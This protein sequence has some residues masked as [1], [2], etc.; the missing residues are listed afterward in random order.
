MKQ[1]LKSG[2]LP[3]LQD[4]QPQTEFT[5]LLRLRG[6]SI[7]VNKLS[8]CFIGSLMDVCPFKKAKLLSMVQV[9]KLKV[10][11]QKQK[12]KGTIAE[13]VTPTDLAFSVKLHIV[14]YEIHLSKKQGGDFPEGI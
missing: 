10:T 12:S 11:F 9:I 8:L 7:I 3:F 6:G 2:D 5:D 4:T 14:G 1:D 13:T